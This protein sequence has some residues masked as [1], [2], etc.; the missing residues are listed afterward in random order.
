MPEIFYGVDVRRTRRPI[1]NSDVI[2]HEP[3]T[4][5]SCGVNAGVVLLKNK[6][7]SY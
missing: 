5:G 4:N 7:V 2:I 1:E 6:A 3:L